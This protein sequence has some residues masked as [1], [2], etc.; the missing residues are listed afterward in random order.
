M[1]SARFDPLTN[2]G[3][4]NMKFQLTR[5]D[6]LK[7]AAVLPA[8]PMQR[9][10]AD[11]WDETKTILSRIKEPSFPK[12]DFDS[13]RYPSIN[14]AISACNTAGGGRVVVPAG[15]DADRAPLV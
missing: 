13:T 2:F 4:T 3:E 5:R 12:R 8:L 11:P 14:D 9:R 1:R 6:L 7:L 10:P 15:G